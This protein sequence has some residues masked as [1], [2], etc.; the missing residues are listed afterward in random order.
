MALKSS[1]CKFTF[2]SQI[3]VPLRLLLLSKSDYDITLFSVNGICIILSTLFSF[4]N[5]IFLV[6]T[7]SIWIT[8][9]VC[10]GAV[11]YYAKIDWN[12]KQW[13]FK[14][15]IDLRLY[16]ITFLYKHKLMRKTLILWPRFEL[17]THSVIHFYSVF[18]I[19]EFILLI[20]WYVNW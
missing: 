9:L 16:W 10:Y 3:H 12:F 6:G 5:F 8:M 2:E 14:I 4:Q 11:Y 1:L 19:K 13:T 15:F 17:K 20:M 18:K 7:H